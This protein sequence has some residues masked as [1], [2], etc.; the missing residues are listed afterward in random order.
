[1]YGGTPRGGSRSL[2][3]APSQVLALV[4]GRGLLEDPDARRAVSLA[5]N[6]HRF[7]RLSVTPIGVLPAK[8]LARDLAGARAL[9][10]RAVARARIA[11][12]PRLTLAHDAG[13]AIAGAVAEVLIASLD[14][15]GVDLRPLPRARGAAAGDA[16]LRYVTL[17]RLAPDAA[18]LVTAALVASG[19]ATRA[20]ALH[21]RGD[22]R[23]ADREGQALHER[24]SLIVLGVR[25]PVA[26]ARGSLRGLRF[27]ALGNLDLGS[28]WIEAR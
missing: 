17:P 6:R 12:R 23:A 10:Q 14:D 2:R 8:R 5:I 22:A 11:G 16:N 28:T 25:T 9:L 19:E 27:D 15:L 21:A 3:G 24:G 7:D 18:G 1:M 26:H 4:P 20:T 13:D